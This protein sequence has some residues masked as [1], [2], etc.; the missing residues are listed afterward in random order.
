MYGT[1][2]LWD[3]YRTT[4]PLLNLVHPEV[5]KDFARSLMKMA[6]SWGALPPW[7]L[8][9]SP[10]DMMEGDGGSIVLA[11]MAR[12]G[13][14]DA[15]TTF[16]MLHSMRD[17]TKPIRLRNDR[18][19]ERLE[20][21]RADECVARVA[22]LTH[23]GP[24][25]EAFAKRADQVFELWDQE[26]SAFKPSQIFPSGM[27]NVNEIQFDNSYTEGTPLQYSWAAE[28]NLEK[29]VEDHG[30]RDKFTCSLDDFFRKVPTAEGR[31]A[32]VTGNMHGFTQGNEPDFHAPYL[33]SL[34][35]RPGRTQAVVDS[36]VK[37]M[38]AD[39]ADGLPGNDDL[40]AMSAWLVL[41]M[42]GFYPADVCG[43]DVAVGRPFVNSAELKVR[44][45][46]LRIAVH[47]QSDE[48]KFV[49][50]LTL[51]GKALDAGGSSFTLPWAELHKG[52]DLVF[53][54]TQEAP[55]DDLK[56][57]EAPEHDHFD[58]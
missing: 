52:G 5:S 50:Q 34:V 45:G 48:N 12:D 32:D 13:L 35:G 19:S 31:Q 56:C 29:L 11:T 22:E 26:H 24:Q 42:L 15:N 44:G 53:H 23:N 41:S 14:L 37:G 36:L 46:T 54:M 43:Q 57:S 33:F 2:S 21:A 39:R 7:Q 17:T 49:K 38:F 8:F 3:T 16:A 40:G 25:V 4:H 47:N 55:E 6:D 58:P 20:Q 51:N 10:T 9:Q 30:G 1:F 18:T 28:W 27:M